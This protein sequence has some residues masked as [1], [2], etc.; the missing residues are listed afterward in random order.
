M[1]VGALV[2]AAFGSWGLGFLV[3]AMIGIPL[4]S[5]VVYKVYGKTT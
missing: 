5:F 2:G 3:G 1:A 4:G